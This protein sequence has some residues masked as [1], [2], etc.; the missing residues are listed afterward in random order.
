[1]HAS[2]KEIE[3]Q[4]NSCKMHVFLH[5]TFCCTMFSC[6]QEKLSRVTESLYVYLNLIYIYPF[7]V[8]RLVEMHGQNQFGR[9]RQNLFETVVS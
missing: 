8:A 1:M 5:A 6:T 2:C 7:Q 4:S 3:F 9:I